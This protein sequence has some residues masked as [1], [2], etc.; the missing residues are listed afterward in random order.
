MILKRP[1][2]LISIPFQRFKS[3]GKQLHNKYYCNVVYTNIIS[4]LLYGNVDLILN[5]IP[6]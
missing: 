3:Q 4:C 1:S 6:L 5:I 2:W